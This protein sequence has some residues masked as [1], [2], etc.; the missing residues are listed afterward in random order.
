MLKSSVMIL[1]LTFVLAGCACSD[2]QNKL[3]SSN[4]TSASLLMRY[5]DLQLQ[6]VDVSQKESVELKHLLV[7]DIYIKAKSYAILNKI[8]FWASLLF[9]F[10]VLIWPSISVIFGQYFGKHEWAK[11]ATVQTTITG[12]AALMFAFYSQYKDKQVNAE[13]LMRYVVY[14]DEK[15]SSLTAK[16]S[17]E[18]SKIDRGFSFTGI[19]A[20]DPSK[21]NG[22]AEPSV[23][24]N[25][26]N[27]SH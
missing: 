18:L 21:K 1:I 10:T 13:S 15:V 4:Q 12:L 11:S 19:I 24:P 16:V 7:Y 2:R 9:G 23:K 8:F 17:E 26:E 20:A 6:K 25:S 22:E 14:S 27:A 3:Y 5:M